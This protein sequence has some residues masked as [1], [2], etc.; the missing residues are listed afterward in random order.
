MPSVEALTGMMESKPTEELNAMFQ[1]P[2]TWSEEALAAARIVLG[3]RGAAPVQPVIVNQAEGYGN[4]VA[5]RFSPTEVG[6][7]LLLYC[8]RLCVFGPV[9]IMGLLG[10]LTDIDKASALGRGFT[11]AEVGIGTVLGVFG[12]IVGAKVWKKRE[13]SIFFARLFEI[14]MITFL[15]VE[16]MFMAMFFSSAVPKVAGSLFAG[17]IT[18]VIWFAY[19]KKSVRVKTVFPRG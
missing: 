6:G 18:S 11:Y 14:S 10:E 19:L 1:D 7:W 12:V 8:V 3:E 9:R 2:G 13:G 15:V 17:V 4:S 5:K 16:F